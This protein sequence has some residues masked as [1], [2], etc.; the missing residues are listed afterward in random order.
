MP[1]EQHISSMGELV[2]VVCFLRILANPELHSGLT[3]PSVYQNLREAVAVAVAVGVVLVVEEV[4]VAVVVVVV[5]VEE[6]AAAVVVVVVRRS[7]SSSSRSS[8]SSS[9]SST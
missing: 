3:C 6:V 2:G 9:S 8:S 4:V 5:A 1:L 7:S